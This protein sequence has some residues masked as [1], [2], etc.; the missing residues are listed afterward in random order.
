MLCM[1]LSAPNL[2]N[3]DWTLVWSFLLSIVL[4]YS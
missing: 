4:K 2:S 3:M 1:S